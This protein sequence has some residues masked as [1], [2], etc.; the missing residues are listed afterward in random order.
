M[1]A[2]ESERSINAGVSDEVLWLGG[3]ASV[4]EAA[5]LVLADVE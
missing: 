1:D 4:E 3:A 5:E 2:V